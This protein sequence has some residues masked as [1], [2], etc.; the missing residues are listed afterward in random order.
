M[1]TV[2]CPGYWEESGRARCSRPSLQELDDITRPPEPSTSTCPSTLKEVHSSKLNSSSPINYSWNKASFDETDWP[3]SHWPTKPSSLSFWSKPVKP[4]LLTIGGH[5]QFA[6]L[7]DN[8]TSTYKGKK[9]LITLVNNSWLS[10]PEAQ[11]MTDSM[12]PLPFLHTTTKQHLR[13]I[14]DCNVFKIMVRSGSLDNKIFSVC[15]ACSVIHSEILRL[16]IA[17]L[18]DKTLHVCCS[19][20]MCVT[21]PLPCVHQLYPILDIRNSVPLL[22]HLSFVMLKVPPP[23]GFWN[24]VYWRALIKD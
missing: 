9:R 21:I 13:K 1:C 24:K 7:V 19:N 14:E 11:Q 3:Q 2:I 15:D 10:H 20:I 23:P 18:L 22:L 5:I 6:Q 16:K 17:T 12:Q 8:I 4:F